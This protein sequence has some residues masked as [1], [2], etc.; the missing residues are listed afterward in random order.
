MDGLSWVFQHD[1]AAVH[2]ARVVSSWL[3]EENVNVLE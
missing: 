3:E 1:H 2:T